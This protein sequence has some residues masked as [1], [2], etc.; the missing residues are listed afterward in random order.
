MVCSISIGNLVV[1]E[2][3]TISEVS[4]AKLPWAQLTI[5][6]LSDLFENSDHKQFCT[7]D[8][9]IEE[10]HEFK[11]PRKSFGA[12]SPK[13]ME[14][15]QIALRLQQFLET[16]QVQASVQ[17]Q[18]G[19][20][21]QQHRQVMPQ[22]PTTVQT[23]EQPPA[24]A[25]MAM[26]TA[27]H[28]VQLSAEIPP[29]PP[30]VPNKIRRSNDILP[31]NHGDLWRY[32]VGACIKAKKAIP[33]SRL[34]DGFQ[35]CGEFYPAPTNQVLQKWAG[36]NRRMRFSYWQVYAAAGIEGEWAKDLHKHPVDWTKIA[37]KKRKCTGGCAAGNDSEDGTESGDG[38]VSGGGGRGAAAAAAARLAAGSAAGS[39]AEA[40]S[41]IPG[42]AFSGG[43]GRGASAAA[44][45]RLAGSDAAP[46]AGEPA[47]QTGGGS[48]IIQAAA[49]SG[50]L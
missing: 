26:E 34:L 19:N 37:S 2:A 49:A 25:A 44:A 18:Q 48:G 35:N 21:L 46:A 29:L 28:V 16:S 13:F 27:N 39:G 8:E 31:Y 32:C 47:A 1:M 36:R 24:T 15:G 40:G 33:G 5:R 9:Y 22:Q 11:A 41:Y 23:G 10:L 45:A 30:D 43:G 17:Q 3:T 6:R 50:E 12:A 42:G 20:I 7:F 14:G 38:A 4:W